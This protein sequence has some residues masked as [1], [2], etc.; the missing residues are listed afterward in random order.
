MR[1]FAKGCERTFV[2]AVASLD[3]LAA[4]AEEQE[5]EQE[6]EQ[7]KNNDQESTTTE[8]EPPMTIEQRIE[9]LMEVLS[10]ELQIPERGCA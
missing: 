1:I 4:A 2:R 3:S 8:D 5:Q 10:G 7:D 9:K 6:Q